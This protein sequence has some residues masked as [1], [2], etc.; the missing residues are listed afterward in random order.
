VEHRQH[1]PVIAL[2]GG[3]SQLLE[4]ALHVLQSSQQGAASLQGSVGDVLA[5]SGDEATAMVIHCSIVIP[6]LA[7]AGL[8]RFFWRHRHDE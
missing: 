8:C 5:A 3:Q 4:D 6:L 1:S 2:C 7:L